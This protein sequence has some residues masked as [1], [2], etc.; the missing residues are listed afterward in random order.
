[1]MNLNNKNMY[2]NFFCL[3]IYDIDFLK[4]FLILMN[5]FK[6]NVIFLIKNI[7]TLFEESFN[8]KSNNLSKLCQMH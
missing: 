2:S 1:M 8:Y 3:F 7:L 4:F 6:P 5:D